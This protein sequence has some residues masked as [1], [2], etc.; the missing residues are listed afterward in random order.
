MRSSTN[1]PVVVAIDLGYGLTKFAHLNRANGGT[2]VAYDLFPSMALGVDRRRYELE[3]RR[4]ENVKVVSYNG[5]SFVVGPD[6]TNRVASSS[7]FGRHLDD[8]YYDSAPYHALMRGAL[9][10]INEDH[11]D[12]LALGL[13][14][15]HFRD[16][17]K[18]AALKKAYTGVVDI[19]GQRQVTINKVVVRPQPMGGF[20]SLDRDIEGINQTIAKYPH[21]GLKP[22]KD[23]N[24]LVET[25]TIVTVDP[26]EYTL[27]WLLVNK[28][29]PNTD[30]SGAASDAG[31]HRVMTS[32]KEH[33]EAKIGRAI[34][35][36]NLQRLNNSLRTG[37]GFKLD[38]RAIDMT[39]PE[40]LEAA[41][42]AVRDPVGI[43][44]NGIKGAWD[45][46]DM[47]VLVGG[48][49][50]HY[51]EEIASRMPDMPIYVPKHSVFSNV[52]GL[53]LIGEGVA[54][55]DAEANRSVVEAA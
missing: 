35:P 2:E 20:Y 41:R 40:I 38:G 48:H 42:R 52:E 21:S 25:M 46:I 15:S 23:W 39:D 14:V 54:A 5:E 28:G 3:E 50:A 49:P 22:L 32:V 45:I 16:P 13:P 6:V 7:D 47:I 10:Y 30:V 12:V 11:I 1:P 44:M 53:Q 33:L 55:A 37:A 18:P 9:S 17:G 36:S 19:D 26:G 51:A 34:A 27:D 4:S 31:R 24:H 8:K 29:K 43:M